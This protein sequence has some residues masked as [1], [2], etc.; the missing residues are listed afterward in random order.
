MLKSLLVINNLLL[1]FCIYGQCPDDFFCSPEKDVIFFR[2]S[3]LLCEDIYD[4]KKDGFS[5]YVEFLGCQKGHTWVTRFYKM[6]SFLGCDYANS[7]GSYYNNFPYQTIFFDDFENDILDSTKWSFQDDL[8]P[9]S[10]ELPFCKNNEVKLR[11]PDN[12]Y[13]KDGVVH[14][15]LKKMKPPIKFDCEHING[16]AGSNKRKY[17]TSRMTTF[18]D[19]AFM[20]NEG[21]FQYGLFTVRSKNPYI[22]GAEGTFWMFGWGAEIDVFEM[23]KP[24]CR[25]IQTNRHNYLPDPFS[26]LCDDEKDPFLSY[27]ID[28]NVGYIHRFREYML[29]WTPHKLTWFVDN[30]PI[31][32]FHRYWKISKDINEICAEPLECY[33]LPTNNE[34]KVWEHIGWWPLDNK[35]DIIVGNG[36]N[37]GQGKPKYA[38][39]LVDWVK[40]EQKTN[41]VLNG[42]EMV[43][44]SSAFE[45]LLINVDSHLIN[46]WSVSPNLRIIGQVD[47][48]II[49]EK[50]LEAEKL[51]TGWVEVNFKESHSCYGMTLR[52]KILTGLPSVPENLNW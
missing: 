41:A 19:Q 32:T 17:S 38:E 49:V 42:P 6:D 13:V 28:H 8:H 21:C 10:Q 30:K 12:H 14:F 45:F 37:T 52:K 18:R 11:S 50:N 27:P 31:R 44:D 35:L 2:D 36:V 43:C 24:D 25:E 26:N 4:G 3:I 40:I 20:G 51:N 47:N 23:C 15:Q 5:D 16:T 9:N 29:E 46:Y 34:F 1:T 7:F 22:K 39:Y 33:E 48:K